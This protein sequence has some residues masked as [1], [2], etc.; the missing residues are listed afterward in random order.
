[1]HQD[2][3]QPWRGLVVA[4]VA[5]ALSASA[6]AADPVEGLRQALREDREASSPGAVAFRKENLAKHAA[7]VRG[8]AD[9]GRALLLREWHVQSL[10]PG[11]AQVDREVWKDL[12]GRF[13]DALKQALQQGDAVQKLAALD[14]LADTAVGARLVGRATA[15]LQDRLAGFAESLARLSDPG[16]P[17]ELR[18]AALRTLGKIRPDPKAAAAVLDRALKDEDAGQRRA[19][20]E[21]LVSLLRDAGPAANQAREAAEP[22]GLPPGRRP[23]PETPVAPG[24]ERGGPEGP[25]RDLVAVALQ[26]VPVAGHALADREAVVRRSGATAVREAGQILK[27]SILLPVALDFPPPGRPLTAEES[28]RIKEY[29]AEV[30]REQKLLEPLARALND[31]APAVGKAVSDADLG[32]SSAAGEALE[33]LA[34]ARRKLA[35]RAATVPAP[36]AED[37]ARPARAD[38]LGE[39]LKTAVRLLAKRLSAAEEPRARLVPLYVLEALEANAAPAAPD[40]VKALEDRDAFVRWAA[41]RALGKMELKGDAAEKAVARLAPRLKDDSAD[42]RTSTAVAL[43]RYGPAARGT[44]PALAAAVKGNDSELRLLAISALQ[45]IGPPAGQEAAGA[46]VAAL[47]ADEPEV[48]AAAAGA[49][50]HVGTLDDTARDALRKALGDPEDE[51]RRAAAATLLRTGQEKEKPDSPSSPKRPGGPP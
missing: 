34:E 41:V 3:S 50:G 7:A 33:T 35:Q 40:V 46:L 37:G 29:R 31:Q 8:A 1:M 47:K 30:E 48:R 27:D 38:P 9:L 32:V 49:L 43:Q 12:A 2:R 16:Q 28:D 15:P 23:A 4:A 22:G 19:A 10:T 20:A 26:V 42:V 51:V 24:D 13:E 36:P 14:V 11:V 44:V 5:L 39:G 45:A 21:A 25:P 17:A 6:A 18:A